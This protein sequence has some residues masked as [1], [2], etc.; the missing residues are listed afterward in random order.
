MK[1]KFYRLIIGLLVLVTVVLL[2]QILYHPSYILDNT[3]SDYFIYYGLSNLFLIS[4]AFTLSGWLAW[5]IYKMELFDI[6]L[7]EKDRETIDEDECKKELEKEKNERTVHETERSRV[8]D[9]IRLVELAK[10]KP[11]TRT[12]EPVHAEKGKDKEKEK[13]EFKITTTKKEELNLEKLHR[14]TEEY[15]NII[16]SNPENQ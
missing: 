8:N 15:Y 2:L 11:E 1:I 10:E 16:T 3:T 9:F 7:K 13:S 6:K 5:L 4:F 12:E 14:L